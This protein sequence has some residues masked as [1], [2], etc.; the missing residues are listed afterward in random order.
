MPCLAQGSPW[1]TQGLKHSR[2]KGPAEHTLTV[3]QDT[4][5]SK[6]CLEEHEDDERAASNAT[7]RWKMCSVL[8]MPAGEGLAC[9]NTS[10]G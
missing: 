3:R 8:G 9:T 1:K 6:S 2:A 10:L 4:R 5:N 7:V